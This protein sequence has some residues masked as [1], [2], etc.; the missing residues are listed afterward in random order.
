RVQVARRRAN[1]DRGACGGTATHPSYALSLHDALPISY[2]LQLAPHQVDLTRFRRLAEAARELMRRGRRAAAFELLT[3]AV[4]EWGDR[5]EEHT[6]EL[7]SRENVVCRLL[8]EKKNGGRNVIQ[9][10]QA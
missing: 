8:L 5:S 4:R 7:Q 10:R 6:S 9:P 2:R 1:A 3:A